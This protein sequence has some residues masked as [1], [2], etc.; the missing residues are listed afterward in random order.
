LYLN[1]LV[2]LVIS[3]LSS[4]VLEARAVGDH[5]EVNNVVLGVFLYEPD[6]DVGGTDGIE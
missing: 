4:H 3:D 2:V 6:H 5:V 1:E